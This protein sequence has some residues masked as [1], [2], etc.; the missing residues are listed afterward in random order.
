[1]NDKGKH[2][3][4][5]EKG[6]VRDGDRERERVK[7]RSQKPHTITQKCPLGVKSIKGIEN[8]RNGS[9]SAGEGRGGRPWRDELR[10]A[11]SDGIAP[12]ADMGI[13]A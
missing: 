9:Q 13:S 3:V 11:S 7:R 6:T 1:M 2:Q 8:E 4:K 12:D 5:E 10:A